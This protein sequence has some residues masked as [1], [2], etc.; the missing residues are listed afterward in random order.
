MIG[1]ITENLSVL[2]LKP[3]SFSQFPLLT[4]SSE[5]INI[6]TCSFNFLEFEFS[7]PV[8]IDDSIKSDSVY[9]HM[10]ITKN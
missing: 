10:I 9:P 8:L 4:L 3:L 6:F 2:F 5:L 1:T 7:F